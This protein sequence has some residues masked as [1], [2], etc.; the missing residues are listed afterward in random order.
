MNPSSPTSPLNPA[1]PASPTN[2]ANMS[3]HNNNSLNESLFNFPDSFLEFIITFGVLTIILFGI[4][5][6]ISFIRNY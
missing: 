6:A 5:F 4:F 1:N 3:D 2:P